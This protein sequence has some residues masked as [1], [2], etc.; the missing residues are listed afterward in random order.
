[1][2]EKD[3]KINNLL[4]EEMGLEEGERRRIFDQDSGIQYQFKGKD[5]VSPGSQSGKSAVE[6]DPINNSKMMNLMFGGFIDK[7][8]EEE[9][10]PGV[11]SYYTVPE[12]DNR[13]R[14][15]ILFDDKTSIQSNPYKN[16]TVCYA[17]LVLR[18]NGD[19]NVDLSEYDYDRTKAQSSVKAPKKLKQDKPKKERKTSK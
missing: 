10:I 18:L 11:A 7:L 3:L 16:E 14:A 13:I 19:E 15:K 1:M 6:F 12:S 9:S 2:E 4:M 8:V 17:D 5:I